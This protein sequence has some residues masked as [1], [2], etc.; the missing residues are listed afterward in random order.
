[1]SGTS[2]YP[3]CLGNLRSDASKGITLLELLVV[4]CI[5]AHDGRAH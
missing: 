5:L 1:M 4:I 3:F 2:K